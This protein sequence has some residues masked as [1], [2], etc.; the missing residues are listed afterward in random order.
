MSVWWG[1]VEHGV[2]IM[3]LPDSAVIP[4]S[5]IEDVPEPEAW[6]GWREE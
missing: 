1:L 5:D 6:S 2:R 4:E 3:E